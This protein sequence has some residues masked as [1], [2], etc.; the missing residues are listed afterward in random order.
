MATLDTG[1]QGGEV[2]ACRVR[3]V[4]S[5]GRVRVFAMGQRAIAPVLPENALSFDGDT[6]V[7]DGV[8]LVFTIT[9]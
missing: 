9:E 7:F 2:L 5:K 6:L 4:S 8:P 1:M 3:V